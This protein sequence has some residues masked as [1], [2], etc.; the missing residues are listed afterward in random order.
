MELKI[1]VYEKAKSLAYIPKIVV[2]AF[3]PRL[4]LIPNHFAAV[5]YPEDQDLRKVLK[6]IETISQDIKNRLEVEK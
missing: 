6:S 1:K 2:Q 3:G 4:I 5:L